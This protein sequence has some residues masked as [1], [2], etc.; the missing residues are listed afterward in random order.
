LVLTQGR[1]F[2]RLQAII[3]DKGYPSILDFVF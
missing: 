2:L 3:L 1:I